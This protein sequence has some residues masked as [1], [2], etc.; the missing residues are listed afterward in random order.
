MVTIP[1]Q[2]PTGDGDHAIY[3]DLDQLR[4]E[5]AEAD[6]RS[7]SLETSYWDVNRAFLGQTSRGLKNPLAI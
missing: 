3:K 7:A 5:L 6:Q 4:P 2:N 1:V